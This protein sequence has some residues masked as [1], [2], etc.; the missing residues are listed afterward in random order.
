MPETVANASI[1]DARSGLTHTPGGRYAFVGNIATGVLG[2]GGHGTVLLGRHVESGE[3]VAIKVVST[4]SAKVAIANIAT[5]IAAQGTIRH[6]H[7]VE[8]KETIVDL[9]KKKVFM[10]LELCRGGELFDRI[11]ECGKLQ[12]YTAQ[13]YMHQICLALEECHR[14]SVFHRD[15]KPENILLSEDDE[16]KVADFGL[17]AMMAQHERASAC[18]GGG[19]YLRHTAVGS[20]MYAAPEVVICG[21]VFDTRDGYAADK[22][23]V[24]SLGIM[25]Y[26]MLTG[27]LPYQLAHPLKCQRYAAMAKLGGFRA[28][29]AEIPAL[30]L[31]PAA[32]ELL[33]VMLEPSPQRR[34]SISQVV[35]AEWFA[36]LRR[37]A[38]APPPPI[39]AADKWSILLTDPPTPS[40]SA[41]SPSSSPQTPPPSEAAA[42]PAAV[43]GKRKVSAVFQRLEGASAGDAA[44]GAEPPTRQRRGSKE[45]VAGSDGARSDEARTEATAEAGG[46]AGG[47]GSLG[48]LAEFD[49]DSAADGVNSLLT[50]TLGWVSMPFEKERMMGEVTTALDK[51]GVKY[52]VTRGELTDVVEVSAPPTVDGS[53]ASPGATAAAAAAAASANGGSG[54]DGGCGSRSGDGDGDG[55]GDGE[56]SG[57]SSTGE[58]VEGQLTVQVQIQTRAATAAGGTAESALHF[59]RRRGGFVQFHTFYRMMREELTGVNKWAKKLGRY[60]YDRTEHGVASPAAH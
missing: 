12:E 58:Y 53:L 45:S 60:E 39:A 1:C 44:G 46:A 33:N 28:F 49:G 24:W 31:S 26:A 14:S 57:A 29:A 4:A 11:A 41:R 17:A 35:G 8:L 9:D 55:D 19:L 30:H 27:S 21:S 50:R 36:H 48:G 40:V 7:V 42:A 6:R 34:A 15:L 37:A 47:A 32:V 22:A 43:S 56:G 5:E 59:A 10:V 51:L 13:R 52:A 23:D 25:M 18:D 20:L 16:V 54:G 38:P 2:T 3:M